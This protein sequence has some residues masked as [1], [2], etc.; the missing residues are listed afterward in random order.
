MAILPHWCCAEKGA[1][2]R[3]FPIREHVAHDTKIMWVALYKGTLK[4]WK[5]MISRL[6][7]PSPR[8]TE[9]EET[10]SNQNSTCHQPLTKMP[11]DVS[12]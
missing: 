6:V 10:H 9:K 4:A 5:E 11:L 8:R 12:C 3:P 1:M 2:P 7:A